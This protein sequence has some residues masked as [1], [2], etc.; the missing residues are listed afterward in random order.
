LH[1]AT[2]LRRRPRLARRP[3]AGAVKQRA[4]DVAQPADVAEVLER[5]PHLAGAGL[6]TR[7]AV[8][9]AEATERAELAHL[10]VLL[11]LLLVRQNR[12]RLADLLEPLG[13][14]RIVPVRVGVVLLRQ[15]AVRL[16][17]VLRRRV[18]R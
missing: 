18:L 13:G 4:E 16:L 1:V 3:T 9:E 10:V 2:A 15:P 14:L 11:A 7:G 8:A 6:R 5:E 12:V 17:D